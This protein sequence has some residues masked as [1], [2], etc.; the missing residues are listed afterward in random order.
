[1]LSMIKTTRERAE[2][3][4][5]RRSF[6][7]VARYV[8]LA[9]GKTLE[10]RALATGEGASARVLRII[11]RAEPGMV[12]S[13]AGSPSTWGSELSA[14]VIAEEA[15][16]A[17]LRHV[18]AVD[19]MLPDTVAVPLRSRISV[20]ANAFVASETG[21]GEAKT[22]FELD[23][24]GDVMSPKKVAGILVLTAELVR[25]GGPVVENLL[26]RELRNAITSGTDAM[27]LPDLVAL[28]TPI[29][30][31]GS[32]ME[33]LATALAQITIGADSK[34]YFI[35]RPEDVGQLAVTPGI[36]GPAFP[37]LGVNGGSVSGI[38]VV[39]STG[40]TD[41]TA[42]LLDAS[43][44]LSAVEPVRLDSSAHAMV[45]LDSG[46]PATMTSLWQKDMLG[47]RAERLLAV[48][49]LRSTAVQSFSNVSYSGGSPS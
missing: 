31:S 17:S 39:V 4:E 29:S 19:R 40:L 34:L 32:L 28:T 12:L 6:I 38:T 35:A 33:D 45:A 7:Q 46:A 27:V 2:L 15:F 20:N 42:L 44:L 18:G 49:A 9:K 8:M 14:Y 30:S 37:Q 36:V 16:A 22:V 21:E 13:P 5:A 41:G 11:E 48:H 43:Q 10:A 24:A 47:L 1:M 3:T 25:A 23:V 26:D